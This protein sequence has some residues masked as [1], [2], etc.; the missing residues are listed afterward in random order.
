MR[1]ASV[2]VVNGQVVNKAG[3][4]QFVAMCTRN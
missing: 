1:D 2:N 3:E 4:V